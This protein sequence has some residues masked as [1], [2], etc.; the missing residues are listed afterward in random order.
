MNQGQILNPFSRKPVGL[1]DD[2]DVRYKT[3][4]NSNALHSV[5]L[6]KT[7]VCM[8]SNFL[9]KPSLWKVLAYL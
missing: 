6:Y 4:T 1:F 2:F 7:S 9:I 5:E 3:S 8:W